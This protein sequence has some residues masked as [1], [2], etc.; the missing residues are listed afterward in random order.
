MGAEEFLHEA[1]Y[2][3]IPLK[4]MNKQW[5]LLLVRHYAGHWAF[6]KGHPEPGETPVQ[7]AE[8]ELFEETGLSISQFF[9]FLPLEERY[10]FKLEGKH[11][12]KSVQYFL[13][14]VTGKVKLQSREI[15]GSMWIKVDDAEK[16]ATFQESQNLC[17]QVA[18]FIS[19]FTML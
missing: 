5:S 17:K 10:Q 18:K 16:Y 14:E 4:K 12:I 13:A 19:K 15:S 2:G 9:A 11:I 3:I 6:P 7:T 8:R 1:S